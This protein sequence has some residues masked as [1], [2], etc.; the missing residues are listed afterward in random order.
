M[1]QQK[2]QRHGHGV[3]GVSVSELQRIIRVQ[4]HV[5]IGLSSLFVLLILMTFA[6]INM[7]SLMTAT[8]TYSSS[9]SMMPV[10][11]SISNFKDTAA[12]KGGGGGFGKS[13]FGPDSASSDIN[14]HGGGASTTVYQGMQFDDH[15]RPIGKVGGAVR[16]GSAMTQQQQQ[17]QQY[18]KYR[19]VNINTLVVPSS[20]QNYHHS[21]QPP[22]YITP[23]MP[24]L[25]I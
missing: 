5:I 19:N 12:I 6:L 17:Q 11:R 7:S 13:R 23:P 2:Q 8:N 22:T 16:G 10:R 4:N 20:P 1:M 15:G 18:Y 25:H 9:S 3:N 14:K 21:K 24:P